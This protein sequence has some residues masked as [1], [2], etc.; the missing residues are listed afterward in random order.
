[1]A[2]WE[3]ATGLETAAENSLRV[4]NSQIERRFIPTIRGFLETLSE[5]SAGLAVAGDVIVTIPRERNALLRTGDYYQDMDTTMQAAAWVENFDRLV[6][7]FKVGIG[8]VVS[9]MYVDFAGNGQP[10]P[11]AIKAFNKRVTPFKIKSIQQVNALA[12]MFAKSNES[13]GKLPKQSVKTKAESYLELLG[14]V[15]NLGKEIRKGADAIGIE[16]HDG[17]EEEQLQTAEA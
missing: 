11:G 17:H 10:E 8:S 7:A 3:R 4:I 5:K 9:E 15:E 14:V 16:L 1:M 12:K 6:T 2:K 13:I